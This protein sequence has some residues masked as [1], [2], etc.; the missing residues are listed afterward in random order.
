LKQNKNKTKTQQTKT[1]NNMYYLP[2]EI[3]KIIYVFLGVFPIQRRLILLE[4]LQEFVETMVGWQNTVKM[5]YCFVK[6]LTL[7]LYFSEYSKYTI[8]SRK[9]D[10]VV[11][12]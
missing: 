11:I 12:K 10:I 7:T 2:T 4:N 8:Y 6:I 9:H 5:Y 3:I 1:K